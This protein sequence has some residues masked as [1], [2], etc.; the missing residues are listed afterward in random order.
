MWSDSPRPRW[1]LCEA[2]GVSLEKREAAVWRLGDAQDD[3]QTFSA[4]RSAG[5]LRPHSFLVWLSGGCVSPLLLFPW[6]CSAVEWAEK[7]KPLSS[8]SH[9][10]LLHGDP[11]RFTGE[12][13]LPESLSAALFLEAST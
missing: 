1:H 8:C 7:E 2:A 10:A 9:T 12:Q 6:I 3:L 5:P 11:P 4:F 13:S